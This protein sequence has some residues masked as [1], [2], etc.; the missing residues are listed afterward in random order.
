MTRKKA[1]LDF[2][3]GKETSSNDTNFV[4]LISRSGPP[5]GLG[6]FDPDCRPRR[7]AKAAKQEMT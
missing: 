7:I 5:Q 4:L 6:G 2:F 3:R 1:F